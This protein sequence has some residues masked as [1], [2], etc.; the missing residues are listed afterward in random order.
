[1]GAGRNKRSCKTVTFW[2]RINTF[3]LRVLINVRICQCNDFVVISRKKIQNI[4]C[5]EYCEFL[6]DFFWGG[7]VFC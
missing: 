6:T 5:G 2:K 4:L 1:M 7:V 3:M